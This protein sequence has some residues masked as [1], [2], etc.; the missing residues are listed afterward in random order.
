[1]ADEEMKVALLE[2]L[3]QLPQLP[4]LCLFRIQNIDHNPDDSLKSLRKKLDMHIESLKKSYEN[5]DASDINGQEQTSTDWPLKTPQSLKEKITSLF[6]QDMSSEALKTFT[7]ASCGEASLTSKR[8][9][10]DSQDISLLPLHRPDHHSA[11]ANQ[12]AVVDEQWLAPSCEAPPLHENLLDPEALL[13]PAGIHTKED[14]SGS[15]LSFCSDC[16]ACILKSKMPPL[17]LANHM[18][19][20]DIPAELQGLTIVE[21]AMIARCRAKSWVIQL[22]AKSDSTCLPNTQHGL[23]GHTI[24]YPQ[25]PQGLAHILPLSLPEICTSICII[26]VGSQRPSNQ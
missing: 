1:M 20:G 22:Q 26:F 6:L 7:C 17:A 13:D 24:V 11:L 5:E 2:T 14:G 18:F 15:L 23:K 25:Q 4:M 12:E 21:E 3:C 10:I 9:S 8:I 16:Y 19:L